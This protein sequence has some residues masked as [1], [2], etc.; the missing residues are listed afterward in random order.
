MNVCIKHDTITHLD[1]ARSTG[2]LTTTTQDYKE[3][4]QIMTQANVIKK[5]KE[6]EKQ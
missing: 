2:H 3:S 4:P 5:E 6:K 1:V